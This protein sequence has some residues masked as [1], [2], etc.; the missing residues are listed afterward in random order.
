MVVALVAGGLYEEIMM[1]AALEPV[2]L[3]LTDGSRIS[4][5]Y[6]VAA[7]MVSRGRADWAPPPKPKPRRA[8]PEPVVVEPERSEGPGQSSD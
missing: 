4:M 5:P 8:E 2:E 7:G 6:R 3:I 1:S